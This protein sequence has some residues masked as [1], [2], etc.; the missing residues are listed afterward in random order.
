MTFA[1]QAF[2]GLKNEVFNIISWSCFVYFLL[3]VLQKQSCV[4]SI[5]FASLLDFVFI[6]FFKL[7]FDKFVN[8]SLET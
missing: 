1:D 6:R 5:R 4:W 7:F 8:V 2:D 3:F